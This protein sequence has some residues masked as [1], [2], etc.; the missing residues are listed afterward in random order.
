MGVK[1]HGPP[2]QSRQSASP[3]EDPEVRGQAQTNHV[4]YMEDK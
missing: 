4:T 1:H 2:I 3:M